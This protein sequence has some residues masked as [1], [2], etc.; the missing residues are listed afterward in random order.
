M[1]RVMRDVIPEVVGKFIERGDLDFH[2]QREVISWTEN[3][4]ATRKKIRL[5]ALNRRPQQGRSLQAA[6][7][8]S[9]YCRCQRRFENR[10]NQPV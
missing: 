9:P 10:V 5:A 4:T 1:L 3:M 2:P 8:L 7:F 6:G